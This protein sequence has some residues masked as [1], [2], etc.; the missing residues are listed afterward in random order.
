VWLDFRKRGRVVV[1]GWAAETR[2]H[3]L[4]WVVGR[5]WVWAWVVL[6]PSVF[7]SLV[8]REGC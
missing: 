5:V 3:R 7:G 1:D 6:G 4:F 8:E 2:P